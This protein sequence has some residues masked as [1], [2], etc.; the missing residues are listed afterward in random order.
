MT[1]SRASF[2]LLAT[3]IPGLLFAPVFGLW[4]LVPPVAAVV[5]ACYAV[6]LASVRFPALGPWR[7]VL[8]LVVGLLALVEVSL[9]DTTRGG[10]P[11]VD[12][13]RALVAG[14]T[15]SWQLTLQSTW[16]VRPEAELL[17]FVPL[18]VL[19]TA[20]MGLELLR[21]PAVAA[22]PSVALL[23][24]SQAFVAVSGMVATL[25]ALA[26]A[27]VVAGLYFTRA[28]TAVVLTVVLSAVAGLAATAIAPGP[29]YS[30]RQNQ[31]AHVQ[32]PRTV[33]P[34]PPPTP[35]AGW[36]PRSGRSAG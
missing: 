14:V 17:L 30:V 4:A 11:T 13:L 23:L 27:V 12:S 3:A 15:D 20:L 35:T 26:Y 19:L 1:V 34:R 31:V 29:A 18:L 8:A 6:F 25:V 21:W 10:V 2:L 9:F 5:V 16:P 33:S 22:L 36:G 28:R 24:L 32:L 7:P